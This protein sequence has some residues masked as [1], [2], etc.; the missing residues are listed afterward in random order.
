VIPEVVAP[1]P[2][3]RTG[4]ERKFVM[5][6]QCPV[7]KADVV[8]PEGES[9]ARCPNLDCPAQIHGRIVHF[10]SRNALDIEHLGE[11]TTAALLEAK[12]VSDAA[13]VFFLE[14]KDIQRLEGF[15]E[16]STKNLLAAIE[17][18]KHRS[19]DRLLVAMGIRHVGTTVAKRLCDAI[20]SIEKIAAASREEL[21]AIEG[22]G[23]VVAEAVREHFDRP[24][25][26]TFL[27][28]LRR[29]GVRLA[30]ERKA[31]VG[32]LTGKTFIVTGTLE[33][34]SREVAK[35]K[36][37]ALGGKMVSSLSKKTDYLVVGAN[38][39][40]K[41]DKAQKLGVATLDEAAFLAMLG[42]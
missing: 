1:I 37:E 21:E 27:D 22:V 20:P 34:M 12:L 18:G 13:D 40:S 6:T 5:P 33:S 35:E 25:T 24:Q 2:S 36:L 39:S 15:K 19:I 26:Q 10:A 30:E 41:V 16:K 38:P 4:D 17:K 23:G 9:V 32:P 14:A 11:S 31:V 28:K 29:A 7:C 3:L 8:Q 42:S